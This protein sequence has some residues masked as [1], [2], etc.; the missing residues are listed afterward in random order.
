MT[1]SFWTI[2]IPSLRNRMFL[3]QIHPAS[4]GRKTLHDGLSGSCI[5]EQVQVEVKCSQLHMSMVSLSGMCHMLSQVMTARC[6]TSLVLVSTN[7]FIYFREDEEEEQSNPSWKGGAESKF[8]SNCAGWYDGR[9]CS[10][11]LTWRENYSFCQEHSWFRMD[12]VCWLF[13]SPPRDSGWYFE[14]Y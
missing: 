2:C 12:S 5:A 6:V 14:K 13:V 11:R 9:C 4:C 10:L 7:S 3:H 8:F 1:L